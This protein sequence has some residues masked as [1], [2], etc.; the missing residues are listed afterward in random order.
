MWEFNCKFQN[1]AGDI[2]GKILMLWGGIGGCYFEKSNT[3]S[4]NVM[5]YGFFVSSS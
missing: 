4:E 2:D 3:E 1:G 5:L